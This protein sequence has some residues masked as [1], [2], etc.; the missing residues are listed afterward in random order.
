MVEDTPILSAGECRPKNLIFS[1]ISF[2]AILALD[3]PQ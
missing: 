1:E 2:V 3:R